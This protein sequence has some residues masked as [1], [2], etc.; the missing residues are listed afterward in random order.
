MK[1]AIA[2]TGQLRIFPNISHQFMKALQCVQRYTNIELF[3]YVSHDFHLAWWHIQK[4]AENNNISI[5][6]SERRHKEIYPTIS[7]SKFHEIVKSWNIPYTYESYTKD[8]ISSEEVLNSIESEQDH[9]DDHTLR[10]I[11]VQCTVENKCIERILESEKKSGA[12]FDYIMRIRPDYLLSKKG[13]GYIQGC[14]SNVEMQLALNHWDFFY[15]YPRILLDFHR[16]RR[17]EILKHVTTLSAKFNVDQ[18]TLRH[19]GFKFSL[20]S[21]NKN[22]LSE[23]MGLVLPIKGRWGR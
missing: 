8:E 23:T 10:A 2:I 22:V 6:E 13:L 15:F 14:L 17:V 11:K 12:E 19:C 3:F 5:E 20:K 16:I 4:Y 18:D 21:D 9:T 1:T 7:T